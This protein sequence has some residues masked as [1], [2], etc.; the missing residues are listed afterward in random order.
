[1][2]RAFTAVLVFGSAGLA[3]QTVAEKTNFKATSRHADVLAFCDQ[4]IKKSPLVHR[5]DFGKSREGRVLPMLILAD[6][7]IANS[8]EAAKSK[9]LVVLVFANIH[10]GEVDGKEAVLML[11]AIL[12]RG[13]KKIFSR[14]W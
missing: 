14:T 3:Q 10:A 4:L 2:L 6:P 5:I 13:P 9:K 11:A 1:M 12:P 7:P 8:T